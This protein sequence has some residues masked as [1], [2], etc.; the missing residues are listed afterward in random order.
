MYVNI[1]VSSYP[2]LQ[3]QLWLGSLG[4]TLIFGGILVRTWRIHFIFNRIVTSKIKA[5][6]NPVWMGGEGE[7]RKGRGRGG[8][9]RG[10]GQCGEG[11]GRVWG[12]GGEGE[13][14]G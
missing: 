11:E 3:F 5:K 4:F 1:L 14:R 12:G 7:E 2:L 9:G 8:C 13:G 10:R 6:V